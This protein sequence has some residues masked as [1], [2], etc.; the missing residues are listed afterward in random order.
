MIT[1]SQC[2]AARALTELT[3]DR[4]ASLSGVESAVIEAFERRIELPDDAAIEML[5]VTLERAG[6][7]FIAENGGGIGVR[8]KFTRSEVK[9]LATLENEGGISALDD[10][11]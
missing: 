5:Q 10:V 8:L 4:L 1:G 9:R 7:L 6:A 11:P 3:R 2:R